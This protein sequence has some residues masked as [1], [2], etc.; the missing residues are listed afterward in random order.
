[1]GRKKGHTLVFLAIAAIDLNASYP[2]AA[3]SQKEVSSILGAFG[4]SNADWF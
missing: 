3:R 4:F 1:L 2:Y